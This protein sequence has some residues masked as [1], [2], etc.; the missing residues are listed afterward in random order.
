MAS[1]RNVS[2]KET[3][4][5]E[6]QDAMQAR[7]GQGSDEPVQRVSI[8]NRPASGQKSES[9]PASGQKSDNPF[10]A[11]LNA[12]RRITAQRPQ[13]EQPAEFETLKSCMSQLD[14]QSRTQVVFRLV[15]PVLKGEVPVQSLFAA[16]RTSGQN[17]VDVGFKVSKIRAALE[18]EGVG[19]GV[20]AGYGT[21]DRKI[22]VP[23][24]VNGKEWLHV[25]LGNDVLSAAIEQM[26][27]EGRI[28]GARVL[29]RYFNDRDESRLRREARRAEA[30]SLEETSAE[31]PSEAPTETAPEATDAS[32][33]SSDA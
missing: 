10:F 27:A 4:L 22:I 18:A 23:K 5:Q 28:N 11:A 20:L 9:R 8:G 1:K 2:T 7:Q 31:T 3:T 21:D 17:L 29:M 26:R 33:E 12:A 13:D 19:I 14:E 24:S 30:T 32:T 6:L 16:A 25:N 15:V